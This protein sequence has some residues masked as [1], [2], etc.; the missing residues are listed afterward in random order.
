MGDGLYDSRGAWQRRF[1]R[2][3]LL[4]TRQTQT[5]TMTRP[6][7]LTQTEGPV[8][9]SV[10][11]LGALVAIRRQ[12]LLPLL[13]GTVA[14]SASNLAEAESFL[15]D[16]PPWLV[17]GPGHPGQALPERLVAEADS[18]AATLRFGLGIGASLLLLDGPVKHRAKLS[19]MKA[20]GTVS[21]L[22]TA[23]RLGHLSAVRP[24]VKALEKLGQEEVLPPPEQLDALWRALEEMDA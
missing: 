2:M 19:Y 10:R 6:P 15:P 14:I 4:V 1:N 18:H 13:Y 3:P 22:V 7:M 24:M 9:I 12:K 5:M 20:V 23:Y 16:T 11:T 21:I 8:V 17:P